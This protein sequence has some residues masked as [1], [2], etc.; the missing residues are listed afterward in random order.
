M[1]ALVET[2]FHLIWYATVLVITSPLDIFPFAQTFNQ[3]FNRGLMINITYLGLA[4]VL[5]CG[6]SLWVITRM[7]E[8]SRLWREY[9]IFFCNH[10]SD[11]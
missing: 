4:M 6:Y 5:F 7:P 8:Q 9:Q 11:L 1:L 3:I 2:F 10:L